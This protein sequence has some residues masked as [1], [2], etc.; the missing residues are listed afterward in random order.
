MLNLSS[1]TYDTGKSILP[2]HMQ[3]V[4][5]S[6]SASGEFVG[7]SAK[8]MARQRKHASVS[9]PFVQ[10]CFSNLGSSFLKAAKSGV[11]DNLRGNLDALAWETV[12]PWV[13]V[14][15]LISYTQRR[16]KSLISL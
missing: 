12:C 4:A 9:S 5:N 15:N 7:L 11:V 8:G 13:Q 2:K 10:A 6:L 1:A 14:D 3:L 16:C